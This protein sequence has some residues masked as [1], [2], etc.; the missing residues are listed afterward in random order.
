MKRKTISLT[1]KDIP[2]SAPCETCEGTGVNKW[3]SQPCYSCDGAKTFAK[4]DLIG[5]LNPILSKKSRTG[6][7]SKRPKDDR[8][9]WLWR[10]IRFHT[11]ADVTMPWTFTLRGD[12]YA[13]YIDDFAIVVARKLTGHASAGG[14]RWSGLL[15]NSPLPT[16]PDMPMTAFACGP[17]VTDDHDPITMAM[18]EDERASIEEEQNL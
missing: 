7:M 3:V 12:P 17:V 11:G 10:M 4:P 14:A 16:T 6:L 13:S 8:Q 2:E 15:S 18:L 1:D 9:A 5:L